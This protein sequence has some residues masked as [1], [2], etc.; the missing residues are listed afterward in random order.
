MAGAKGRWEERAQ[1]TSLAWRP[2]L[3]LPAVCIV[4]ML[5]AV[6]GCS[7]VCRARRRLPLLCVWEVGGSGA[8]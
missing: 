1:L 5:Q 2:W 4:E 7:H 8:H 6:T 3:G